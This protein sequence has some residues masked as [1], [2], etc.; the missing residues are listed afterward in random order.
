MKTR[1]PVIDGNVDYKLQSW[2]MEAGRL[3]IPFTITNRVANWVVERLFYCEHC[4]QHALFTGR[5]K[6]RCPGCRKLMTEHAW[7]VVPYERS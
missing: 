5:K 4:N 7:S 6:A 1:I 2:R 3:D